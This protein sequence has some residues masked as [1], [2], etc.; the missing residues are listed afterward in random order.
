M[1]NVA[2]IRTDSIQDSVNLMN[3]FAAIA[4]SKTG[5]GT[6]RSKTQHGR[7]NTRLLLLTRPELE[8]L[9]YQDEIV[10]KAIHLYPESAVSAWFHLS[11]ADMAEGDKLPD[12]MLKYVADL[13]DREDQTDEE[14]QAEIYGAK[15]AFLIASISAKQFGKSYILMGIDDGREFWEP[16][17]KKNVRSLRWLQVYDRW[18]LYPE[19][20]GKLRRSPN[21]YRLYAEDVK[22]YGQRI[23]KSRLLQF[24]GNRIYSRRKYLRMGWGDDGISIIQGMFDAYNDWNQG[25]KAGSA[26]LADYDVFT[27][28]M[29]GLAALMLSDRR[30]NTTV[31]QEAVMTRAIALDE[32]KSAVRGLLYDLENEEP[33]SV[34]RQYGGAKDIMDNL[35]NR[36][37]AV[38]NIPEFKLFGKIGAQG[39]T[40]NQ[41][42]AMRSEWA[43]LT[44]VW[45]GNNLVPPMIQLLKIAFL[46]Q[47]SPSKGK[48]PE[49]YEVTAPFDLPLTDAERMEFEKLAA[50][51]SQILVG[52]KSITPKEIRSGY[53][54]STFS[55]DIMLESDDI[56][57]D[58]FP[59]PA[60]SP[61][62]QP[63]IG[64][65]PQDQTVDGENRDPAPIRTDAT[66]ADL[67][68]DQEWE[69]LA[70]IS[71][72]DFIEVAKD[73]SNGV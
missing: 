6:A 17:D 58:A 5:I 44:K 71:A 41:G 9:P 39:L 61:Q 12:L 4:N 53:K 7:V 29:K 69:R 40:N 26:M 1:S 8:V 48:V 15:E 50:E 31:G 3:T 38:T 19:Y 11:I 66:D 35:E 24:Y 54:G 64:G 27:L 45:S 18:D 28:G 32:G 68:S 52:I 16:V 21:Y 51:R 36:W 59:A 10:R 22:E 60:P 20:D 65:K 2:S 34:T 23:H 43:I 42:L 57:E 63:P 56:P 14:A 30:N 47:D 13:G 46:A 73:V 55:P 67:L 25:V 70:N 62:S 49:S 33:G 72:A 37:C